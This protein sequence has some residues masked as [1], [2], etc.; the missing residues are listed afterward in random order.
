[1][2]PDLEI[3]VCTLSGNVVLLYVADFK[4]L[5]K[6]VAYCSK[7]MGAFSAAKA[8]VPILT[9]ITSDKTNDKK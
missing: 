4:K 5:S 8:V 3:N 6:S 2:L 7:D 9:N 1:M